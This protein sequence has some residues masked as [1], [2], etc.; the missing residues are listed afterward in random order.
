MS[1]FQSWSWGNLTHG[2]AGFRDPPK[3]SQDIVSRKEYVAM[4]AKKD[5][6]AGTYNKFLKPV[7]RSSYVGG[8]FFLIN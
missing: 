8:E 1:F 7:A 3:K 5:G 6:E 4:L 2:E